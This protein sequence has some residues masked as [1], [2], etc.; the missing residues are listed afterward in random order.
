C[1]LDLSATNFTLAASICSTR[2]SRSK[3]CRYINAFIATSI[4]RYANVTSNLGVSSNMSDICLNSISRTMELYGVP[5]NAT[6]FCGFGTKIP[7]NYECRGRTTV[8][9]MLQSPKF[10]DVTQNCKVPLSEESNCKKCLN[11]GIGYLHH[12][13]GTDDNMTLSTCRDAT[14][15]ALASQPSPSVL[16][17]EASPSPLVAASP[18]QVM[19]GLPLNENHRRYHLTL[20]PSIGIA[21]TVLA[22]LILIVL[23]VLIRKKSRELELSE[24][25]DKASSRAFPASRPTRKLQEG[26]ASMFQRFS[27][28]ETKK[29]T[30]NFSTIIG[31]GGFGTVYKGQFTD[32]SPVAV[33]RMDKVSEQG[34]D[35]FCQEIELLARLHHRHLEYLHFYCDPPLCHRDI[36]SSNIL[37]D[38]NFV[39]KVADFGLA[40]ASKDGSICFEPV[41]TTDIRGTPESRLPDLVDSRIKDS[42]DLDQLQTMVTI[43][44]WCTQREG[45]ARPSIKQVLRLLYESSDPMH[46]GFIRAVEDE[47]Y[48]GSEGG[49]RTSKGKMHRSDVLLIQFGSE[50]DRP[51]RTMKTMPATFSTHHDWYMSTLSSLSSP[52]GITPVHLY[53]YNHVM[54]GF[55][56]VLS[57]AQLE[58]LENLPGHVTT[59][60]ESIGH[61]HTTHTPKFL[62]LNKYTGAWPASRFGDDVIIGVL[63]SG[64]WPESESF[65][66]KNMP[67]VPKRWRGICET[68]T[69]FN[70][71][72]CNRK[73]IGARK[74]SQ[75]MKQIGLNISNTDDYDSPRDY[76]GHGTHTSSTAG[77]S[78]VSEADYFGY[79]KGTATG[80]APSARIAMY[81]VL[82]YS[83]DNDDYDAAATDTLA[84]MDQAIEDG[85]DIMSLSLG[86][87]ETTPFSEN[88]IAVGAFAAVK[89]GIFVVCSAGNGGPHGYTMLNGAPWLTTVGAG[90]IDRQFGAQITLDNGALTITGTS[91]FPE[92]LFISRI[93]VYFGLGNRSKEVCG[94][95]ALNPKDVKG[96]F[97]FCDHDDDELSTFRQTSESVRFGPDIYGAVGGIFSEDDG[98]FLHPDYFSMPIVIVNTKDGDLIK[99]YITSNKNATVSVEFGKTLLG[100]SAAP[101]VAYFSS[102]GPDIKSPWILKPDVLAPGFNILA[103]WV[104]NRGFAPIREEDYLLTDYALESGTSMS[105]PHVAGIAAL[106]K[107]AHPDWSPA[108]IRSALMTT[109]DID[110]NRNDRIID[111]TTGVAGTPLDFGAGHVDPSKAMDPGLV[112]DTE[113]ESYI[114]YLCALNYTSKQIQIITRTSNFTCEHASLDLNYP[115]FMVILN[116]TKTA[117]SVF[118]RVLMNVGNTSSVYHAVL[119]TPPGM[120]AIVQPS[121]ITFARKYSTAEFNL[122]VKINLEAPGVTPQ[123]DYFGNYGYLSWY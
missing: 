42:F 19:L 53:S 101:K 71:S 113:T 109:A 23:I 121:T 80:M 48:E 66:D 43:V 47:E 67:P 46:S 1:P 26:P 105:C 123:S 81:K 45:R 93:P 107:A 102:R 21:V 82:F 3:C 118:K 38:E 89:K 72:H 57:A 97:L 17:P 108:A 34:E 96:K 40:H 84:G 56:A 98:E 64:I 52:D 12:L 27:Y 100:T 35:D 2:E 95:N 103:A 69:E 16:T 50:T 78:E 30:D 18:S 29:A 8:N 115:S 24:C 79:A 68:G 22:F 9:Q 116:K 60:P 61:Q 37:L 5:H 70:T 25:L 88:P 54:D 41:N 74:F 28:K 86:F 11:A 83:P 120:E 75:G 14:Y 119:K 51:D 20:V 104:P 106:L 44:R 33:K 4:A 6:V 59:F 85:V 110:D 36:K 58:E 92:N 112:Y 49:G 94:W 63:D 117:T 31:Q 65:N 76:W 32:G 73:L 55:S 7:V 114:S 122:T 91:I 10:V 87:F 99:K 15:V 13:V 90:T 62:G 111:M 77:G 39:A